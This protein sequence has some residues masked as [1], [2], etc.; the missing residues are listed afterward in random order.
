MK[1]EDLL[2]IWI[3]VQSIQPS[4]T[5]RGKFIRGKLAHL[6]QHRTVW[7][8][9]LRHV[10][11]EEELLHLLA[12]WAMLPSSWTKLHDFWYVASSTLKILLKIS[13]TQHHGFIGQIISNSL[14]EPPK[15]NAPLHPLNSP[16]SSSSEDLDSESSDSEPQI[17]GKLP[18]K[19]GGLFVS[20]WPGCAHKICQTCERL[21][22][23]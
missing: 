21:L 20:V 13:T 6:F 10:S 11:A 5:T 4:F 7:R 3:F 2:K 23:M 12:L 17:L 9:S 16:T 18:A 19:D 22:K 15:K 1:N 14:S 8:V